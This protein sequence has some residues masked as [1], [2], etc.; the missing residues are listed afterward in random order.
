MPDTEPADPRPISAI[1][2]RV[3]ATV[4]R[5]ALARSDAP[6]GAATGAYDIYLTTYETVLS[7]EAFFTERFS[8]HTIT[9]DEG[10]RLKN[11]SSKLCFSL[12]RIFTPFRLLLTG[13][14][15]QNNLNE[16]WALMHYILPDTLDGCKHQFEQAC[17]AEAGHLDTGVV[18]AARTLLESLMIRRVKA[19]VE[20]SLRPK[21]QYV[22]KVPLT[23]LQRQWYHLRAI[24]TP[25]ENR[26]K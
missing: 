3:P 19:E 2:L 22:L 5:V 23:N 8:F 24:S 21:V 6:L 9:I 25:T 26:L 11:E 12:S 4:P 7:E 16:L 15:L 17:N 13:T 20:K 1:V 14:P 18:S 10:H